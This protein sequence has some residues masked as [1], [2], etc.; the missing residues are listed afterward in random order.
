M[1]FLNHVIYLLISALFTVYVGRSL[2][3]NGHLF[4]LECWGEDRLANSVNKFFLIGFYLLNAA[5]VLLVLR[6]GSTGATV[7]SSIEIL[8][9][10]IGFV[11]IV[12]G[13][14]HFNN[15]LICEI[16]RRRRARTV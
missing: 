15:L 13:A 1:A 10:R 12:M 14:M 5:F 3:A 9:G 2:Y 7:E 8:A 4:L 6:Y 16:A 11:V